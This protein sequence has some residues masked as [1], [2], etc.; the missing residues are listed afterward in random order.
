MRECANAEC[1][2][3]NARMRNAEC[4][5]RECE[6]RNPSHAAFTIYKFANGIRAFAHS[7]FSMLHFPLSL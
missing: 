1:G 7:P 2:M 6:M 4:G 3:G 5:M